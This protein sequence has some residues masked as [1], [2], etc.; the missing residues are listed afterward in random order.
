MR[1]KRLLCQA[2]RCCV[3]SLSDRREDGQKDVA[4]EPESRPT[5]ESIVLSPSLTHS[6]DR[7]AARL[8][9]TLVID[10]YDSYTLNLL[11]LFAAYPDSLVR[12]QVVVLRFDAFTWS[13]P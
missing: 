6:L 10:F 12:E 7:M 13:V 8:P 3:H 9:R 5:F 11:T 4:E 2:V 1:D